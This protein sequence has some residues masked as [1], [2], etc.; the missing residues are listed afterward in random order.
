MGFNSRLRRMKL[1]HRI[2]KLERTAE[3]NQP[4][5]PG[6][7]MYCDGGLSEEQEREIAEAKANGQPVLI[8]TIEDCSE[9]AY[10]DGFD[11]EL[12]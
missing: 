3:G 11:D 9:P 6:L 1:K 7:V 2:V 10:D 8:Y 12:V 4:L 5:K